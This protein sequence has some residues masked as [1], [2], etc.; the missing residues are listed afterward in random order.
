VSC[1]LPSQSG[2][3][4]YSQV[5][6]NAEKVTGNL[7]QDDSRGDEEGWMMLVEVTE[8]SG[9]HLSRVLTRQPA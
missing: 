6:L 8:R 3:S 7:E 1:R 9:S 2:L 5:A 4:L